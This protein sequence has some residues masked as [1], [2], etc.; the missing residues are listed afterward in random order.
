MP[1]DGSLLQALAIVSGRLFD[2]ATTVE[3]QG[4]WKR[5]FFPPYNEPI[6]A[7]VTAFLHRLIAHVMLTDGHY[8]SQERELVKRLTQTDQTFHEFGRERTAGLVRP[9][10]DPHRFLNG[11]LTLP[12]ESVTQ[13]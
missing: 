3:R 10:G 5:S 11:Q 12:S 4:Y 13:R 7:D 1:V 6:K 8:S 9:P 2:L